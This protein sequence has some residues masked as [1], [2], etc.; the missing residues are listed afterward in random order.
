MPD[1]RARGGRDRLCGKG[2]ALSKEH[3]GAGVF[4]IGGIPGGM[5]IHA[6]VV[7][8]AAPG[9]GRLWGVAMGEIVQ[10]GIHRHQPKREHQQSTARRQNLA[11]EES[12]E[13]GAAGTH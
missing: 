2:D 5:R 11:Q 9:R 8:T 1:S 6:V 4:G 10:G 3:H 7:A 13:A 12:K